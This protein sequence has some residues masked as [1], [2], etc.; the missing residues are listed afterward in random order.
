MY[1]IPSNWHVSDTSGPCLKLTSMS[2]VHW[3]SLAP[4]LL[5][6]VVKGTREFSAQARDAVL[7]NLS[8]P[9]LSTPDHST[10]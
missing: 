5:L 10:L 3:R 4:P 1:D 7:V 9:L 8:F 2:L 6:P